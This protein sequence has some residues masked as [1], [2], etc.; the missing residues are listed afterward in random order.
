MI[1]AC[2]KTSTENLMPATPAPTGPALL[3]VAAAAERLACDEVTVLRKCQT[4]W[5]FAGLAKIERPTGGGKPV[6]MIDPRADKRLIPDLRRGVEVPLAPG[7][8]TELTA[9]QRERLQEELAYLKR[10]EEAGREA[11]RA[12]IGW[13]RGIQ[14]YLKRNPRKGWSW[15]QFKT[16]YGNK[17]Q[18]TGYRFEGIAALRDGRWT[19]RARCAD[20]RMIDEAIRFY[21]GTRKSISACHRAAEQQAIKEG[22][23]VWKPSAVR[24]AI[25]QLPAAEVAY[26]RV[27]EEEFRNKYQPTIERSYEGL[28]SNEIWQS[29]HYH[30]DVICKVGDKLDPRTGELVPQYGR[31]WK[32]LWFDVRSRKI[33]AFIIRADDPDSGVILACFYRACLEFGVPEWVYI[34]NGR[35][36]TCKDFYGET[37]AERRKRRDE[38]PGTPEAAAPNAGIYA[39]LGV[40]IKNATKYNAR[41]KLQERLHRTEKD[42]FCV[43]WPTY[44]GGN[45][46]EKPEDLADNVALGKAPELADFIAAYGEWVALHNNTI[47]SGNGMKCTP[48]EAYARNL[49]SV[50]TTTR[51]VLDVL[52]LRRVGPVRVGRNGCRYHGLNFGQYDTGPLQ[53]QEVYL[54]VDDA[55]LSKVS[56][57]S[58]E[59]KFLCLARANR[60]LPAHADRELLR[61]AI[62]E[63]RHYS[64]ALRNA[65]PARMRIHEDLPDVM[66][67]LE[68]ERAERLAR[69]RPATPAATPTIIPVRSPIEDQLPAFQRAAEALKPPTDDDTPKAFEYHTPDYIP[70]VQEDAPA[71]FTYQGVPIRKPRIGGGATV[72]QAATARPDSL[73]A[74]TTGEESNTEKDARRA[75]WIAGLKQTGD[76]KAVHVPS[77]DAL[78]EGAA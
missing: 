55:D 31:P 48:S 4:A 18:R 64:K 35:D 19:K 49:E 77:L 17:E 8:A 32:T 47:H 46:Q 34:D 24:K 58:L 54:R 7:I 11:V 21:L 1:A 2:R 61:A 38:T 59:D 36:Y 74:F 6:W 30:M 67:R 53:G 66:F 28:K 50:Q 14:E 73:A 69:S 60:Q 43:D 68:Q 75:A 9:A 26:K 27:G 5:R 3:S 62:K 39:S 52:M 16:K 12:K 40:K 45:P 65:Q 63:Q 10:A 22:W 44:T 78:I 71:R 33:L 76:L 56:V 70:E 15:S 29:D 41:A 13:C 20:R 72:P 51:E 57:W 25:K 42:Q 37:K 23:R